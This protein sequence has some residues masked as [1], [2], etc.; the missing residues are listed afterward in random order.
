[1]FCIDNVTEEH[2]RML[3]GEI[4]RCL[5]RD[6]KYTVMLLHKKFDVKNKNIYTSSIGALFRGTLFL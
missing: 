6:R 2:E 5:Y 3:S 1:M 4:E